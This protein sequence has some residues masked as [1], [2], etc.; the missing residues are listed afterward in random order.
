VPNA[1]GS[2]IRWAVWGALALCLAAGSCWGV[3]TVKK[4]PFGTTLDGQ[5]VDLY[6]LT[7]AARME[8]SITN[9]GAILVSLKV[10][11]RDGRIADVVLGFDTLYGYLRKHP[12]FG[13]TVGRYAN[14][15]AQAR[16]AIDGVECR[17]TKNENENHIHGGARGFDKVLWRAQTPSDAKQ[18]TL[19]LHYLSKDGEEGYPGNLDV[20]V[21]YTLTDANELI[22]DYQATTDKPTVL[23]L[24]NHSY[25]NLAGEGQG[26]VLG[27]QLTIAADRMTP[28]VQGHIP[29]GEIRSVQ[30]T[31]FD[32]TR[33]R[34][35]GE[36][37]DADDE[38]LKLSAGYGMN[39]LRQQP[40]G[41]MALAARV[42]E[43]GSG[44]VLEI[45]TTEPALQLYTA[46][47][48]DGSIVGK[49][50]KAYAAR[51]ALC[52]EPQHC[53]DSPNH[54]NFP[55]TVLRP[56]QTFHSKTIYKFSV[57]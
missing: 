53:P 10:P 56:G 48:L 33:P 22:I 16:I 41:Q 40:A 19:V 13:A 46:N 50:G 52:L 17:L 2:S 12:Y 11:D 14:R 51:S 8:A 31:P 23:N 5:A 37:I 43:P 26:D 32:F 30:G 44:R 18:P 27:N 1:V 28:V 42:V 4:T 55:S 34:V 29:T 36:R 20:T 6:T 3:E 39:Y 24:T 47:R 49:G 9:Y 21:T 45:S 7:N 35:I 15:I 25:F 54:A 38:F 57:Q